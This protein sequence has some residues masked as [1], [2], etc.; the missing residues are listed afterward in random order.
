MGFA[1]VGKEEGKKSVDS[2]YNGHSK[3]LGKSELD[4]SQEI[5]D[6]E[7]TEVSEP[8]KSLSSSTH[9]PSKEYTPSKDSKLSKSHETAS[10]QTPTSKK[11]VEFVMLPYDETNTYYDRSAKQQRNRWELVQAAL[12]KD[13][14]SARELQVHY[15]HNVVFETVLIDL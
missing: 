15:L 8:K 13:I 14:T 6:L 12:G 2:S 11:D 3:S 10:P 9:T 4:T 5:I 1:H 7:A